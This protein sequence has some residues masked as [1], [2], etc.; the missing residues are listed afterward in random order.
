MRR[1]RA[2]KARASP[3]VRLSPKNV[4]TLRRRCRPAPAQAGHCR[5]AQVDMNP[6]WRPV[7]LQVR[8][9][10]N[11]VSQTDPSHK[12]KPTTAVII[13]PV[14]ASC[15]RM[16]RPKNTAPK[17]KTHPMQAMVSHAAAK[18]NGQSGVSWLT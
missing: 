6:V 14:P 5:C 8:H 3:R 17:T 10:R 16:A 18:C 11:G 2:L 7:P 12:T 9:L 1:D 15:M 13:A 4:V